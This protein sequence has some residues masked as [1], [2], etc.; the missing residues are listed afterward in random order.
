MAAVES[1]GEEESLE[2]A[3]AAPLELAAAYWAA[4]WAAADWA[5]DWASATSA[6]PIGSVPVLVQRVL[7]RVLTVVLVW[8]SYVNAVRTHPLLSSMDDYLLR[9]M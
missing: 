2:A 7:K 1:A 5:A 8:A 6:G 4:D 9:V 3:T